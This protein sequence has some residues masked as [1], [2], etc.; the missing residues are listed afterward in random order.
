MFKTFIAALA[1]FSANVEAFGFDSHS[2]WNSG[3]SFGKDMGKN[4]LGDIFSTTGLSSGFGNDQDTNYAEQPR[5]GSS[6]DGK[7]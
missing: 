4:V 2:M 7:S 1:I 5:Y 6:R 3:T